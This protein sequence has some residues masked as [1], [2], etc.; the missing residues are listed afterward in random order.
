M[1]GPVVPERH[2][3]LA[4]PKFAGPA[5][6][7]GLV[8]LIELL[9]EVGFRV[10]NPPAI[11]LTFVVASAFMSGLRVGMTSALIACL[12]F[13][14]VL[15]PP[16]RPLQL[17]DDNVLRGL[18]FAITTPLMAA[19]AGLAKRRGDQIAEMSLEKEREH[20]ASLVALLE[21]RKRV[22]ADLSRAKDAAEAASRAKS[23]FLANMSH[24]IRTPMNGIVGMTALTLRTE[25]SGDQREY[26]DTVR[27]SADALLSL[28]ND[29]LDFSKIEAGRLDLEPVP[30][31]VDDVIGN[32]VRTL[33]LRAHETGLSVTYH[34][35]PEVPPM[36][37]GDPLRL[38]QVLV[39]LLA[40]AI[41]FT[42]RGGVVVDVSMASQDEEEAIMLVAVKD[43]GIGIAK[44][45]QKV[46][47]EAFSQADGSTT[48]K[49]GGT[50]LGLAISTRL[51]EMMGGKLGVESEEG[52]GATFSFTS[53][54]SKSLRHARSLASQNAADRVATDLPADPTRPS[55][56]PPPPPAQPSLRSLSLLVAEDNA[57][58]RTLMTRFLESEGHRPTLVNNGRE[59]VDAT[60]AGEFDAVLM[61]IQM[62]VMDGLE[63]ARAIRERER[64]LGEGARH[65]P[66]IAVTAHAIKGDRE[67]CLDAGYD[68]YV[69]KP[70]SFVDLLSTLAAVVP[71]ATR[72]VTAS[73]ITRLPALAIAIAAAAK[74]P[75]AAAPPAATSGFDEAGA[76]ARVGGDVALLHEV[77]GVFVTEAPAWLAELE[78]AAAAG[79]GV[80]LH[81]VAHTIKGAADTC[82]VR[83]GFDAA[84][85]IE[86]MA[87]QPGFDPEVIAKK[88]AELRAAI[89][90]ALP[91]MRAIAAATG[92]APEGGSA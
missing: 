12:W 54:F 72:E 22:E 26:L 13:S 29:I 80:G 41:K 25:L 5:L 15:A 36:L 17:A 67:R 60:I 65:L 53:R 33:A 61:D 1:T 16:V 10:P 37:V 56:R 78:V 48:R 21:E 46:V 45:K 35:A 68:G 20:S 27:T 49:Y 7:L 24:E 82:G 31:K 23:E 86:R 52:E 92:A 87:R 18:V 84:F 74:S 58:N 2:T 79:D 19:M 39:N 77:V 4:F 73:E 76:L 38:R 88:A 90:A 47:F 3:T 85:A 71:D 62:P 75:V 66:L 40:N 8:I 6:V 30:F 34:I 70:V 43:T 89:D 69:T 9:T 83:G 51:V 42:E 59:A 91:A 50:G 11:V 63:A 14:V 57:V 44:D 64:G 32:S 81:R 28:I 55:T